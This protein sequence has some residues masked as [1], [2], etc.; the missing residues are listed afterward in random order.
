[1]RPVGLNTPV[2]YNGEVTTVEEL[3]RRG[4]VTYAKVDNWEVRGRERGPGRIRTAYFADLKDGSG[5]WEITK[6]AYREKTA[7]A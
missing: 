3:S 2:T 7:A 6:T 1:M 5:S 4:F